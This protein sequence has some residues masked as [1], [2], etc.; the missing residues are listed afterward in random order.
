MDKQVSYEE[1]IKMI[2]AAPNKRIMW[3]VG[4]EFKGGGKPK[5]ISR[6]SQWKD[7]L[8][9]CFNWACIVE[10]DKNT[11]K[12]IVLHGYSVNDMF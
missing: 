11:D 7:A 12:E 8:K 2:E 10:V 1:A 9:N 5:E 6:N 3:A 4:F